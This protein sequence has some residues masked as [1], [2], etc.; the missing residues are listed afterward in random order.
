MS[1]CRLTALLLQIP[2]LILVGVV[3]DIVEKV[4]GGSP[5]EHGITICR[6]GSPG[7]AFLVEQ[8]NL[9]RTIWPSQ[10]ASSDVT[11]AASGEVVAVLG[12]AAVELDINLAVDALI[13][14]GSEILSLALANGDS[15]IAIFG[16]FSHREHIDRR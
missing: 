5:V 12:P 14:N 4:D 2:A 1:M 8:G 3:L 11:I 15:N 16:L 6:R 13:Y 9:A 7:R 10:T